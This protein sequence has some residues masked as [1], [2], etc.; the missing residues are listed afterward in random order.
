MYI[1]FCFAKNYNFLK[2]FVLLFFLL[3]IYVILNAYFYSISISQNLS[4]NVFRLHVIANS[5]SEEDQNL[6]YIVRDNIINYMNTLCD[7]ITSKDD[8][9]NVVS[10]HIDD[11]TKIANQ[12]IIE[13]GFNY[14]AT[15]ELGNYKFPTKTYGDVSFPSGMYDA[16][17]VNL[18]NSNRKKLVVCVIPFSLFY[19]YQ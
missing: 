9:I 5:N 18:G 2:I 1:F 14:N 7:N 10:S 4:N 16:L 15:V 17:K 11:F 6:K 12:T 3:F 13:N 8:A 19:R